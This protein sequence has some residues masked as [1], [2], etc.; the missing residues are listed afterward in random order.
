MVREVGFD[1]QALFV[2]RGGDE[3]Y[4]ATGAVPRFWTE[5]ESRGINA[6]ASIFRG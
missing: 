6:D 5:L 2:Y 3:G 4:G 1:T